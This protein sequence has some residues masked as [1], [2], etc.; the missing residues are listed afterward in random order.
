MADGRVER[1]KAKGKSQQ[2][3]LVIGAWSLVISFVIR[4]F[5]FVIAQPSL[6]I[7]ISF[8]IRPSSLVIILS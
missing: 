7:L 1:Q 5:S 4:P 6:V 3:E 2:E 8:V